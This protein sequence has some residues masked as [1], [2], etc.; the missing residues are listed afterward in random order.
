MKTPRRAFPAALLLLACAAGAARAQ[1]VLVVDAAAG[2]GAHYT[3]IADAVLGASDGMVVLVRTGVYGPFNVFGK[4]VVVTAD[5]NASV[6]FQSFGG[7]IVL[8]VTNVPA[9]STVVLRGLRP[10]SGQPL[11]VDATNVAGALWLEDCIFRAPT[12]TVA[13]ESAVAA[14][15]CASLV[16]A[17][18]DLTG[19]HGTGATFTAADGGRGIAAQSSAVTIYD[20]VLKGGNGSALTSFGGFPVGP[21]DGGPGAEIG[22]GSVFASRSSFTGGFGGAGGGA[23]GAG[24]AVL[25]AATPATTD[26][27]TFVGG[28]STTTPPVPAPPVVAQGPWTQLAG[29]LRGFAVGSPVREQQ[30]IQF[31][32]RCGVPE[33]AYLIVSAGASAP[34]QLLALQGPLVADLNAI[35]FGGL[36]GAC[37]GTTTFSIAAPSLD[38]SLDGVALYAQSLFVDPAAPSFYFGPASQLVLLDASF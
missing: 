19:S 15:Q 7:P 38:P 35:V 11:R 18:C 6:T 5:A 8:N 26:G 17:R 34:S 30:A 21:G 14:S 27:C 12:S 24:L 13:G 2:P 29:P 31:T 4:G 9:G 20:S 33:D 10:S 23:G 25:G 36:L 28:S 22:G 32:Y 37:S 1:N 16:V 3:T